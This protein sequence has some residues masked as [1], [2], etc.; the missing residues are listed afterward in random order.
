MSEQCNHNVE[1]CQ[2]GCV[3]C[4]VNEFLDEY[5]EYKSWFELFDVKYTSGEISKEKYVDI[6]TAC[7]SDLQESKNIGSM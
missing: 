4:A 7:L 6:V 2:D 1:R 5:P 3:I